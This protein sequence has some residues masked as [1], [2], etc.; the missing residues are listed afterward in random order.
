[1]NWETFLE[2]TWLGIAC[3]LAVGF[4]SLGAFLLGPHTDWSSTA[5]PVNLKYSLVYEDNEVQ[6]YFDSASDQRHTHWVRCFDRATQEL[7]CKYKMLSTDDFGGNSASTY[8]NC[9]SQRGKN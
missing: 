9:A 1:M 3:L 4:G 7:L 8:Y 5:P 6:C 2:K